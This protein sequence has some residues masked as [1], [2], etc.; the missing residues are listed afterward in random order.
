LYSRSGYGDV[1]VPPTRVKGTVVIR[2]G[3][4]EVDGTILTWEKRL[5]QGS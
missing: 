1:G 3:P 5:V 4:I 2:T